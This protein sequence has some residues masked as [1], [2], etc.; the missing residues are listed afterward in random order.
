MGSFKCLLKYELKK[1]VNKYG[2][3][4][5]G[6][7]FNQNIQRRAFRPVG[8][9]G[10]FMKTRPIHETADIQFGQFSATDESGSR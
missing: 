2:I 4:A 3:Y 1:F 5:Q 8:V 7:K 10:V 9:F 6:K